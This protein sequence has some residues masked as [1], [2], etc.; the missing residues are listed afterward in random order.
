MRTVR[1]WLSVALLALI[2]ALVVGATVGTGGA[3]AQAAAACGTDEFPGTALDDARWDVLRPAGGGPTVADGALGLPIRAGDLI[4]GTASAENLVLQDAPEGGWTATAE[5]STAAID[6]NGEQAGLVLWKGEG[7]P[8]ASNTFGKIVAIQTNAGTRTF[9]AIWT[10]GGA[11]AVPIGNSGS[12]ATSL[13]ADA[14]IRLR[15][16]GSTITAESS[17]DDGASWA[18]IGQAARY[19]GALRV[20]VMAIGG[21][22]AAGT[23]AFE[24][25]T[26]SCA[27]TVTAS[28]ADGAAPL[29]V[30][31]TAAGAPAGAGLAW[32]FGDGGTAAGAT[33]SHTFT[34]PGTYRVAATA[35]TAAGDVTTGTTRVIVRPAAGHAAADEFNGNALDPKWEVLRP[36]LTGVRVASGHLRLQSYGGDMHGGNATARNVLLQPLPSGTATLT[37][38]I[39]TSELTATGDQVGLVAWRAE[40]PSSFAKVVFNRRGAT[41]YWFE[42]SRSEGT[43][44]TGGNSGAVNGTVPSTVY[45]RIR[46]DGGAN[47]TLTPESSVDG[48]AWSAVQA[49]F[50]LP[51]TGPVKVG[52]TYFSGDAFR[53]AGFDWLRV[54]AATNLFD[55][56]GITRLETRQNS[57]ISGD[58]TRT[59][60]RARRCRRRAP[61]APRRTTRSTTSRC[62]CRTPP[63]TSPTSRRSPARR[64]RSG[65]RTRR[66]SRRSTSSARR[67]TAARPAATSC[68]ATTAARRRRSR[69]GSAT[70]AAPPTT[71]A[72]HWAIG[73][74]TKRWR[75][76]GQDGAPCGIFHVPA[77]ADP[78]RKLVSVT[79]PSTTTPGD[80]PIQSYL[81][82]LS[83]E[84]PDGLFELPDLSGTLQFPDDEI[85]PQYG[86]R[87]RAG[88][89]RP[90]RRAGSPIRSA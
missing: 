61:W 43:G 20:G 11:L 66:R 64:S 85:A 67:P 84:Q 45:L 38:K 74:L 89:P 73:P 69:S 71:R 24:R 9:E 51:G 15:S 81:M 17:A 1:S 14:Q 62:A 4:G 60:S 28:A 30:D 2:C 26:L 83:L 57:E 5:L 37:A 44:T 68:C 47:P 16:D 50:S 56:I 53:T 35:T 49:P 25:F 72:H 79:L 54:E 90:P 33:A 76:D 6:V 48:T 63:A 52:L 23:V 77:A 87:A 13:P 3:G 70:G 86:A 78:A 59:R 42:R 22:G 32:S 8:S 58:P 19:E 88:G 80:P 36:R 46:S 41:Q 27:P 21:T 82:A 75:T 7:P 31:F 10:D 18:R 29:A 55:T 40:N 34:E 65:P 39:D 12:S